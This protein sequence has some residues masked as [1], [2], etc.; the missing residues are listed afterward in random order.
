M[1]F[2]FPLGTLDGK[3]EQLPLLTTCSIPFFFFF[4][5]W[6]GFKAGN[7]YAHIFKIYGFF[8]PFYFNIVI[9]K[10]EIFC[11]NLHLHFEHSPYVLSRKMAMICHCCDWNLMYHH[12]NTV[13]CHRMS[14]SKYTER[15]LLHYHISEWRR[16]LFSGA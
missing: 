11:Q 15:Y 16:H 6:I 14:L 2:F 10:G 12:G 7:E 5:R 13:K 1:N 9:L 4:Y 8:P 3:E